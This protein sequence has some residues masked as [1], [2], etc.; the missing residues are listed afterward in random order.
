MGYG[1]IQIKIPSQSPRASRRREAARRTLP[2]PQPRGRTG[3]SFETRCSAS[4]LRM[5]VRRRSEAATMGATKKL[6]S[7]LAC[8]RYGP[9]GVRPSRPWPLAVGKSEIIS[10]ILASV[11]SVWRSARLLIPFSRTPYTRFSRP[12]RKMS[13][14]IPL[15]VGSRLA[16]FGFRSWPSLTRPSTQRRLRDEARQHREW[17]QRLRRKAFLT[18]QL[19]CGRSLRRNTWMAGTSPAMTL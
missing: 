19:S 3:P 13:V 9:T 2:E 14:F 10:T 6:S 15:D 5:R 8:P 1:P 12:E 11:T 4:H 18:P 16:L 7:A 17:S